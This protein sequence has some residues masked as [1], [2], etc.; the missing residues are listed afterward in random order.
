MIKLTEADTGK[1]VYINKDYIV[2]ITLIQRDKHSDLNTVLILNG[3]NNNA[4]YAYVKESIEEVMNKINKD[5]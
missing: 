1:D 2:Y 3:G 5:E 4:S